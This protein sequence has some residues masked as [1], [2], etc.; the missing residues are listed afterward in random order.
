MNANYGYLSSPQNVLNFFIN[1]IT[2]NNLTK[3]TAKNQFK[4]ICAKKVCLFE[5]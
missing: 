2:L 3:K 4:K 5:N 1:A